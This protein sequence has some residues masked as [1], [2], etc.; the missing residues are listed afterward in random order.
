MSLNTTGVTALDQAGSI[1][2]FANGQYTGDG[3]G[4][5]Q[6][7]VGFTPRYVYI[8]DMSSSGTSLLSVEYIEGMAST[9]TL[10]TAFNGTASIDTTS[11]IVTNAVQYSETEVAYGGNGAGDGTSG[12]TTVLEESPALTTAQLTFG[13]TLNTTGHLYVWIAQG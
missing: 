3:S 8:V 11:L 2:N 10:V 4:S 5:V 9:K 7:F 13:S 1:V 12:T 6:A